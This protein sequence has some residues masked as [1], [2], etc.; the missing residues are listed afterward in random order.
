MKVKLDKG[1]FKPTRAPDTDAGLD[2]RTPISFE[3]LG[4]DC[5]VIRTGVHVELP[6]N[7]AGVIMS[8]SG[9]NVLNGVTCTGLID[10][11]YTGEIVVRLDRHGGMQR[12]IRFGR[13]DKIAQ[14]VVIPVEYVD[15]EVVDEISGG[16]RGDGCCGSTGR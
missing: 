11:G 1:A 15:V 12:P 14:L 2:I 6:P 16:E 8:K 9:L 10:E 13:G 5:A 4:D 3:M 7:T